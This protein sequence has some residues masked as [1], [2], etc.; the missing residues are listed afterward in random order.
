MKVSA[1]MKKMLNEQVGLEAS[2]S[3]TYLAMASWAELAGYEGTASYFYAQSAEERDHMLRII[4]YMNTIGIGATIPNIDKPDIT[5]FKSIE[6]LAK[7]SLKYEQA[8]TKAIHKMVQSAQKDNDY[9]TFDFLS[10]FVK[11]QVHEESQFED[12]LQKFD[13]IGRD[14]VAVNE[15][16]KILGARTGAQNDPKADSQTA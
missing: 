16:D 3:H 1:A 11:E 15:I 8:V 7:M 13:N 10:W 5:Q 4:K 14:G 12:I 9:A 6:S 2:A